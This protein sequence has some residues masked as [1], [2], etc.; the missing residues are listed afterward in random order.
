MSNHLVIDPSEYVRVL[1]HLQQ[2]EH[3]QVAFGFASAESVANGVRLRVLEFYL[4]SSGELEIQTPRHV[5]LTEEA[6]GKLI[7]MAWDR[8]ASLVELHSHTNPRYSAQFSWSDLAGF[9]T[10]VPH[11]WWR[12][13]GRPYGAVVVAPS[14]FDALVWRM[15]PRQPERLD[16]MLVGADVWL[17]TNLTLTTFHNEV[18]RA[19][20]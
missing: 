7:K 5:A 11:V 19:E 16:A 9:E 1:R 4:V 10:F 2:N 8:G 3:E 6:Q 13:R 14:G 12:L 15:D 18:A 17:P 20:A